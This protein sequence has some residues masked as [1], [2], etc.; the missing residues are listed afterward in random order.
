V[1][2]SGC[3]EG[4]PE[5][6]ALASAR[7]SG[8]E[9]AAEIVRLCGQVEAVA[10]ADAHFPRARLVELPEPPPPRSDRGGRAQLVL[11]TT[12][13]GIWTG[14]AI[15]VLGDVDGDRLPVLAP[16]LGMAA[17][18]AGSLYA[19]R[20]GDVTAGQAWSI[21]TGLD[22][23]TYNGLLWAAA[24][25]ARTDKG[26]V[27]TALGAGMAGGAVGILVAMQRPPQGA[28]EMVRSGGLYGTAAAL[29]GALLFAPDSPSSK[30]IFTTLATGMDVGLASG[31]ALASQVGI[32]RNRML[33]IDAGSIAGLG[34]GLGGAWLVTGSGGNGRHA[35]G[36]GGLVGLGVGMAAAIFLTRGMDD[37]GEAETTT[38]PAA[39]ALAARDE[40]GRW[41]F[42]GF[43]LVPVAAPDGGPRRGLVGAVVPLVAGRL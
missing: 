25:D 32:S 12:L 10:G 38:P 17:G 5:L 1:L 30:A 22:Y 6:R 23:G 4:V 26:V 28:V 3:R 29:M 39:S 37:R 34:F 36:A 24:R 8:A 13:Y 16:L 41:S 18:L 33:L 2:R 20:G 21:I 14:I 11:G 31:A 9:V 35:L 40:R 27:G 15:D 7:G 42:G 43:T 19:T